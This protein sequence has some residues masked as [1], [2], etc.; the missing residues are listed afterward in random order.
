MT[1]RTVGRQA[2]TTSQARATSAGVRARLAPS[3][4]SASALAGLRLWT[5][6]GKPAPRRFMA[7]GLP[8]FPSPMKPI[9]IMEFLPSRCLA[10]AR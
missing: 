2:S 3:A 5:V 6:S 10:P 4:V 9:L 1:A 7:M 8:M